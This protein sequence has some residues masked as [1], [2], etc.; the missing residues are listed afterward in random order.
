M[1]PNTLSAPAIIANVERHLAQQYA[2]REVV[3]HPVDGVVVIL[4]WCVVVLL[5]WK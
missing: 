1:H 3:Q 5:I 2:K 4:V